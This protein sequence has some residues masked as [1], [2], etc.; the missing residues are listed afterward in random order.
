MGLDINKLKKV[1]GEA[2][3]KRAEEALTP[4]ERKQVTFTVKDGNLS[5]D[6]PEDLVK[7]AMEGLKD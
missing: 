3:K 7:K 5:V 4:E 6:G 1:A 2:L